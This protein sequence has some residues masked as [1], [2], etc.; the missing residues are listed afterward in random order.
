MNWMRGLQVRPPL[1]KFSRY[2]SPDD[3]TAELNRLLGLLIGS[4][5]GV[6]DN[7]SIAFGNDVLDGHMNIGEPFEC[8]CQVL[9]RTVGTNRKPRG[10]VGTMLLIIGAEIAISRRKVLTVDE[11]LEVAANEIFCFL[12]GHHSC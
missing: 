10:D 9:L 5:P 11:L 6:S 12:S 2:D 7:H 3:N 4:A 8:R 1:G